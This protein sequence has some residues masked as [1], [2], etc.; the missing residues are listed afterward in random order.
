M[1]RNEAYL[2]HGTSL[3][4]ARRILTEGF[5]LRRARAGLFGRGIYLAEHVSKADQYTSADATT[6][7][8]PHSEARAVLLC[9][10]SL[11][12]VA[13]RSDKIVDVADAPPAH[14]GMVVERKPRAA[15]A[16]PLAALGY[17]AV[18]GQLPGHV[19]REFVV[20]DARQV[21]PQYLVTYERVWDDAVSS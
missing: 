14:P 20:F 12:T 5:D 15:P 2:W 21:F 19:Y 1:A 7:A 9:R 18:V 4:S 13:Y 11:G 6:T 17:T 8:P 16:H 10:V 3:A